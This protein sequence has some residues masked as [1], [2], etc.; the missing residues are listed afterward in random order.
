MHYAIS[1]SNFSVAKILIQNGADLTL[2]NNG[3]Q[4]AADTAPISM[5]N[6]TRTFFANWENWDD[7]I[8]CIDIKI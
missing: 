6:Q 1:K 5:I 2:R 8:E 7:M 3:G 4:T